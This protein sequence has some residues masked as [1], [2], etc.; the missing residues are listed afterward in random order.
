MLLTMTLATPAVVKSLSPGGLLEAPR[1][2]REQFGLHGLHVSTSLL[3]GADRTALGKFRDAADRAGCACL[4]LVEPPLHLAAS[5]RRQ[6]EPAMARALKLI[7][8][9]SLLGC[10]SLA[11]GVTGEDDEAT[12]GRAVEQFQELAEIAEKR[13]LN[14]LIGPTKGLTADPDRVIALI[15]KVGGFRIGTYPD[16]QTAAATED[17]IGY[18][19]RLTPYAS[20]VSA[21]TLEFVNLAEEAGLEGEGGNDDEGLDALADLLSAPEHLPWDLDA[22]V[23]AVRAVGY[24][25]TLA[26]DYRGTAGTLGIRQ[27]CE[28]LEA[29]LMPPE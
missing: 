16:F 18:L 15:K 19:R 1:A 27:S 3:K 4:V 26:V 2:V 6:Y 25:G 13:E 14:I 5:R 12:F 22:M 7:E 24:D 11:L 10:N 23:E 20:A 29:A 21:S 17:P 28:A 9:A 8:A